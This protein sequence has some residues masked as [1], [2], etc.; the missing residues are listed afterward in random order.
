MANEPSESTEN[1]IGGKVSAIRGLADRFPGLRLIHRIFFGYLLGVAAFAWLSAATLIG[2][3]RLSQIPEDVY[4]HPFQVS[5]AAQAILGSLTEA[6]LCLAEL[7]V[8][9]TRSLRLEKV[10]ALR[11]SQD[12][13]GGNLDLIESRYLGPKADIVRAREIFGQWTSVNTAI[14]DDFFAANDMDRDR[15]LTSRARNLRSDLITQINLIRDFAFGKSQEYREIAENTRRDV[16]TRLAIAILIGA[17]LIVLA[18]IVVTGS[19]TRPLYRLR[20]AM[21]RLAHGDLDTRIPESNRTDEIGDMAKAV[22]VFRET[23]IERGEAERAR[24]EAEKR[25]YESE[26]RRLIERQMASEKAKATLEQKV[27]ERTRELETSNIQLRD[28]VAK[29]RTAEESLLGALKELEASSA[30]KSNFLAH[31]SH[32]LRTPLNAVLG[33]TDLIDIRLSAG[34]MEADKLREYVGDI[35]AAGRHLLDMV[36]SIL[37]LTKITSDTIE[38]SPAPTTAQELVNHS[39]QL[40]S[41]MATSQGIRIDVE[42]EEPETRLCVDVGLIKRSLVNLLSNAIK[43]SDESDTV[44]VWG[45]PHPDGYE[46]R[47]IDYGIGIDAHDIAYILEPFSQIGNALDKRFEGTGLGLPLA[48]RLVELNGGSLEIESIPGSGTT[49]RIKLPLENGGVLSS[50]PVTP[51]AK[52]TRPDLRP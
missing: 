15:A 21:L 8:A 18:S 48:K 34:K 27:E 5:N 36:N 51:G 37:D 47:V 29:R 9:E 41:G 13:I 32:E 39:L 7:F 31:M 30:A 26:Q 1:G 35:R 49:V 23:A 11:A 14:V 44:E 33:F 19:I 43:F 22:R 17:S 50:H 24:I 20:K 10:A 4:Q 12:I 2:V 52:Q 46:F 16:Q 45:E 42:L 38:V 6:Q 40:V 28:E 25:A 3:H